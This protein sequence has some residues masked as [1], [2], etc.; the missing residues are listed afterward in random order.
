MVTTL[1]AQ[2]PAVLFLQIEAEE[3][4]DVAESFDIEA[5]P[6]FLVLRVRPALEPWSSAHWPSRES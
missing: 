5:V 2:N 4:P 1:A 6:T 3:Q